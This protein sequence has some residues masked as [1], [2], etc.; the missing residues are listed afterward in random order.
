MGARRRRKR[1]GGRTLSAFCFTAGRT[2]AIVRSTRTPPMERKHFREGS[3]PSRVL[4]TTLEEKMR[5][6]AEQPNKSDS[7]GRERGAR[8]CE[9][10]AAKI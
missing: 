7:A 9:R 6:E 10:S 1:E 5:A 4:M 3:M 8:S 2:S